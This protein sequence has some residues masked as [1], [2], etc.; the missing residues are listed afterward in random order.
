MIDNK[1]V[2]SSTEIK[3]HIAEARELCSASL[4]TEWRK[5][6]PY[7]VVLTTVIL[8]VQLLSAWGIALI[9]SPV[10]WIPAF[11]VICACISA[12]Q[13]WVHE[14]AHF[15]LIRNR[16]LNDLFA[17]IFFA[18]PIGMSVN[19]YRNYHFSHHAHLSTP[20]DMDRFA[21]NVN[22]N[23]CKN[24]F[25]FLL[26][27]LFCI[28]GAGIVA[29]KYL[30]GHK[31]NGKK[32][33]YHTTQRDRSLFITIFCWN[34]PLLVLCT[35]VG[36]WYLYFFMWL[37]PIFGMVVSFNSIRSVAEH[38]PFDFTGPVSGEISI[39][40]IIRTT[41]PGLLEKWLMYQCNFNYHFEHHLYPS[42]PGSSLPPHESPHF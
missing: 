8:W 38:H 41:L 37:Y 5:L 17:T 10:C 4:V 20:M 32:S 27:G 1:I 26:R 23:G 11:V 31:L 24:L 2:S 21:F 7:R 33:D 36:R 18:S 25:I 39:N 19:K 29:S 15:N 28:N 12:M 16:R 9:G 42:M 6:K 40:P 34:I 3:N 30:W 13:L 22:V 14:S 35:V